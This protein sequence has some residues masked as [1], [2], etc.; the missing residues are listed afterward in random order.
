[1]QRGVTGLYINYIQIL[2]TI[3]I[4]YTH[5]IVITRVVILGSP[6][7]LRTHG[8]Y[9]HFVLL[10]VPEENTQIGGEGNEQMLNLI[11]CYISDEPYFL[12]TA[13]VH[14]TPYASI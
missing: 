7:C 11:E 4:L 13:G 9:E 1:M 14:S 10:L 2:Y 3:I 8:T 12:I 5:I 6:F